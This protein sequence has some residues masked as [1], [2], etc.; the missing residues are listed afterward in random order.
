MKGSMI[1]RSGS[2]SGRGTGPA[3]GNMSE[4]EFATIRVDTRRSA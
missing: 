1:R 4:V 3:L 2:A